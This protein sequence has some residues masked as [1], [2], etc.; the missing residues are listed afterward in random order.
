MLFWLAQSL[1]GLTMKL[2]SLLFLSCLSVLPTAFAN[3]VHY[4]PSVTDSEKQSIAHNTM[5]P[6]PCEIEIINDSSYDLMVYGRFDNN[7]YLIPF[8]LKYWGAP[9]RISLY[10]NNVCHLG[11]DFYIE[12]TSGTVKYN[13]YTPVEK[14]IRV[15][16]Y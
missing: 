2:K 9:Q 4:N 15:K 1:I 10:Y 11:M 8:L 6:G 13:G 14:T 5:A 3:D 12:T 16:N 7:L